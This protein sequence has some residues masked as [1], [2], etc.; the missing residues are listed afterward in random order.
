VRGRVEAVDHRPDALEHRVAFSKGLLVREPEHADAARR[1]IRGIRSAVPRTDG[2][3]ACG[4]SPALIHRPRRAEV[5]TVEL[6]HA[7]AQQRRASP[8]HGRGHQ[9]PQR[10]AGPAAFT[11]PPHPD[12]LPP[13]PIHHGVRW[14]G[15]RG[16]RIQGRRRPTRRAR[17][18]R[19]MPVD[20]PPRRRGRRVQIASTSGPPLPPRARWRRTA[21]ARGERVGVRGA[22]ALRGPRQRSR[23]A[24]GF[25][26]SSALSPC[27][28]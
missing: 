9:R 23:E 24:R 10:D 14:R 18:R 4:L 21:R 5:H 22:N 25:A 27:A 7:N 8:A 13:R 15:G 19:Q 1:E 17:A 11:C 12:P 28:A 16:D 2:A 6:R 3:Y 20:A 26:T